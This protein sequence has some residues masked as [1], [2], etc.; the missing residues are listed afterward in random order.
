VQKEASGERAEAI[1]DLVAAT[2]LLVRNLKPER[3][4]VVVRRPVPALGGASL[5][6][7]LARGDTRSVLDV[8]RDMFRSENV[9]G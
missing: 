4:P 7:A 2:D 1:A 5:M 9:A 3:I 6:D 8:C